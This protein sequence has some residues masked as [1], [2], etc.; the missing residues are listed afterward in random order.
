MSYELTHDENECDRC[1]KKVGI[2]NL[3][4]VDF[5]YLD[6]NDKIHLNLGEV[7]PKYK[8]YHHYYI[9]KDCERMEK[10]KGKSEKIPAKDVEEEITVKRIKR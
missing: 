5:I 1:L 7:N 6:R 3:R 10:E 9:C 8:D 4:P 2:K